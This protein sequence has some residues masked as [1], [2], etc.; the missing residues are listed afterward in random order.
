MPRFTEDG[1]ILHKS[2]GEKHYREHLLDQL[3]SDLTHMQKH[4][5][6]ENKSFDTMVQRINLEKFSPKTAFEGTDANLASRGTTAGLYSPASKKGM[7]KFGFKKGKRSDSGRRGDRDNRGRD[8]SNDEDDHSYRRDNAKSRT[9]YDDDDD[10]DKYRRNRR[11]DDGFESNR[12]N[13]PPPMPARRRDESP[14]LNKAMQALAIADYNSGEP[15]DLMFEKGDKIEILDS[16]DDNWY[17]GKL[18]GKV[19]IFPKTFVKDS[20]PPPA[21]RR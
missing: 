17:K 11:D 18:R 19:G 8:Y 15:G 20:H 10:D 6:L 14:E 1:E 5:W 4:K 9:R 7:S 13:K 3:V 12:S 2:K 21:Y 16:V